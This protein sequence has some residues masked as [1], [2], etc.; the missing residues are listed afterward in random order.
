MAAVR[1][2]GLAAGTFV[3]WWALRIRSYGFESLRAR[4]Q[5]I[6]GRL[7]VSGGWPLIVLPSALTR[8]AG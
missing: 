1:R 4:A 8:V 2:V 6:K 5:R 7:S 3:T